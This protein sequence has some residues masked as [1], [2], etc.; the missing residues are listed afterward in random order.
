MHRRMLPK[1]MFCCAIA[2]CHA[3][4]QCVDVSS[5]TSDVADHDEASLLRVPRPGI[6]KMAAGNSH[7]KR[8]RQQA[9]LDGAFHLELLPEAAATSGAVCL[10][11]SP[12][13][14]YWR[15]G[16]GADRD[17]FLLILQG[18]SWFGVECPHNWCYNRTMTPRGSS[19]FW[20]ATVHSFE[21]GMTSPKCGV[22][23]AFCNWSMAYF[24]SCDGV[25][26]SGDRADPVHMN[27]SLVYF[28]GRRILDANIASLMQTHGMNAASAVVL[29]GHSAG[30]L[31]TYLH[32][33][34]VRQKLPASL[35]FYAAIP[36]AGFF[37]DAPAMDRQHHFGE[38]LRKTFSLANASGS[39]NT[40]CTAEHSDTPSDCIFPQHFAKYVNT[41]LFVIQSQYDKWQLR[42]ILKLKCDPPKGDCDDAQLK[43]FHQYRSRMMAALN[44]S[45]LLHVRSGHGIFSEA[46]I[47]HSQT[48]SGHIMD[49]AD[50]VAVP[51]RSSNS[52]AHSLQKWLSS[53]MR[54]GL[55]VEANK[56]AD[57]M[58][59]DSS[60]WPNNRPC[61]RY[62]IGS[63]GFRIRHS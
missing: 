33:D 10:D 39:F 9:D 1:M 16:R 54:M 61:S 23:P 13:G 22:N 8:Q 51:Q 52:L 3:E 38:Q 44:A 55:Q 43:M 26:F 48:V 42:H 24:F 6:T 21:H 29:T 63:I 20:A 50:E 4:Q 37:L 28:R 35:G 57:N 31:A 34:Y 58:H 17:K 60:P 11:G 47:T 27:S 7:K 62:M 49:N 40:Q 32:A 15:Q 12:G 18:G 36:D 14:Y 56:I 25:S 5:F 45:D 59:V 19:K 30:G 41:P 2:T 46:C 53:S